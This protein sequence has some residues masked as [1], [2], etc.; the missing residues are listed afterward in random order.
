MLLILCQIVI[1]VCT[2]INRQK[3]LL[4]TLWCWRWINL[5]NNFPDSCLAPDYVIQQFNHAEEEELLIDEV[6]LVPTCS[7]VVDLRFI[8]SM[9]DGEEY[10]EVRILTS[11]LPST[12]TCHRRQFALN[13][14]SDC[15]LDVVN[16]LQSNIHIFIFYSK[17][18]IHTYLMEKNRM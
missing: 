3:Y 6:I 15:V 4:G 7:K 18:N 13:L 12:G 14:R 2:E 16:I 10:I 11:I 5:V 17:K 9:S 1:F 8:M